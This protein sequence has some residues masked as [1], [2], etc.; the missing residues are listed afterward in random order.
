MSA[1]PSS[2]PPASATSTGPCTMPGNAI[3][4]A[5]VLSSRRPSMP[6]RAAMPSRASGHG[7][8]RDGRGSSASSSCQA[9]W[10]GRPLSVPVTPPSMSPEKLCATC[11]SARLPV[12]CVCPATGPSARCIRQARSTSQGSPRDR[13]ACA[14]PESSPRLLSSARRASSSRSPAAL[15]AS[16]SC[17]S[18][19]SSLPSERS[20]PSRSS[21]RSTITSSGSDTGPASPAAAS[22]APGC[23]SSS[24][25]GAS[26]RRA[27]MCSVRDARAA[28][29]QSSSMR[30]IVP[31][32]PGALSSMRPVDSGP[33]RRP[34]SCAVSSVTGRW[35][36]ARATMNLSPLVVPMSQPMT[37][38]TAARIT[39][40]ASS[41]RYFTGRAGSS[42]GI[43]RPGSR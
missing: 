15:P 2:Q 21:S 9:G 37:P 25:R 10:V 34:S 32:T 35:G 23:D 6:S 26:M 13:E 28:G 29:R 8:A 38:S 1:T 12:I 39:Q 5:S 27:R 40:V 31:R 24:K 36:S 18:A 7:P 19:T 33:T 42:G 17:S 11:S 4:P 20:S 22:S 3:S 14:C 41:F 43:L 30:S 16:S